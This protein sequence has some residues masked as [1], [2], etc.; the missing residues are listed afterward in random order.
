MQFFNAVPFNGLLGD[1]SFVSVE[2]VDPCHPQNGAQSISIKSQSKK[3]QVLPSQS[4]AFLNS[5]PVVVS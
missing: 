2:E 3:L 1:H 4:H 5:I